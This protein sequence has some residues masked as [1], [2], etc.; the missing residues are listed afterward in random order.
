MECDV[1]KLVADVAILADDHV[2]LVK[3]RDV[4]RY[5]GQRGWF[6]PDAYLDHGEHPTDA[7]RRI[8]AEQGGIRLP[9]AEL[10]EIESFGGKKTAW[11][12]VFHH[13]ADLERPAP[14]TP[15]DNVAAAEWFALDALP[16]EREVAHHGWALEVLG[17][18]TAAST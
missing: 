16:E 13:R 2:L 10:A 1:H 11:H 5:D 17:R 8:A 14:I 6:L 9:S 12:L 3:Y 4:S 7:A 15:G 18:L